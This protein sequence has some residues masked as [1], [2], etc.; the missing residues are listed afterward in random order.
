MFSTLSLCNIHFIGRLP[1]N[2]ENIYG[3]TYLYDKTEVFQTILIHWQMDAV[4]YSCVQ[5]LVTLDI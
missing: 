5:L 3:S 2:H 1:R 4:K